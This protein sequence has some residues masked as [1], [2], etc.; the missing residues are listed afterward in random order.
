MRIHILVACLLLT[1][2]RTGCDG[3]LEGEPKVGHAETKIY[4]TCDP[5]GFTVRNDGD[6]PRHVLVN[7]RCAANSQE[8][9]IGPNGVVPDMVLYSSTGTAPSSLSATL[10]PGG[11]E[12][13]EVD[14]SKVGTCM[15]QT[16]A[17]PGQ[18]VKEPVSLVSEGPADALLLRIDVY[19]M[20]SHEPS[21]RV[22]VACVWTSTSP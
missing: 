14:M 18:H 1:A 19:E 12:R 11:E 22:D 4:V 21:R 13:S 3:P 10:A 17:P 5:R 8:I 15:D 20:G 2:C 9:E 7:P 6:L 16:N